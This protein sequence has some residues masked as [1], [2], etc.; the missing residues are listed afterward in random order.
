MTN[1]KK[2][3]T[4]LR[5]IVTE[6]PVLIL[7]LGTCPTLATTT[8]VVSAFSMGIAATIVLICSN[9]VISALRK[10]IPDTVRIPCY[11][12]I[13]AAFVTAVQMLLQAFLPDIYDMLGVY[14]ALIVV[15]CIILGRA[16]MYARKN[17]VVDSALDGIGMG[18]GFML[19]LVAMATLREVIG[20][21]SFAGIEIPF[22]ANYKIPL[23]IQAPGGFL[24]YGLLIALMNKLT[25]KRGGVKKKSFSCEGCPSSASCGKSSCCDTT[26]AENTDTVKEENENA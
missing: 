20:N 5:G 25:E 2:L 18:I 10:I 19:A 7:I 17:T 26:T 11:I 1:N 12:V 22:L 23:L 24:V 16:E 4:L 14:L 3:M 15:N 21:G 9:I 6:N 13:I 8:S